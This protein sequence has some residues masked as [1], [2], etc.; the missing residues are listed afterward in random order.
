MPGILTFQ[1]VK[2]NSFRL[3]S[4]SVI[5]KQSLEAFHLASGTMLYLNDIC[6]HQHE[7]QMACHTAGRP[8][9]VLQSGA[10]LTSQLLV[11]GY[12]SIELVWM[13]KADCACYFSS[14]CEF[15]VVSLVLWMLMSNHTM[16]LQLLKTEE[17][18]DGSSS[19]IQATF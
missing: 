4:K 3:V 11:G 1:N 6:K 2:N 13:M 7:Q 10:R 18:I 17:S 16:V 12:Q 19:E 14:R 8:K 15:S 5:H 9:K